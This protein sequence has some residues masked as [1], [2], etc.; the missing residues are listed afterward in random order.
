MYMYDGKAN[1]PKDVIHVTVS[2]SVLEIPCAAFKDCEKLETIKLPSSLFCIGY[3]AF[4][5]CHKLTK[6]VIPSSVISI[7][8]DAFFGCFGLED[9]NLPEGL[10]SIGDNAFQ[11]CVSL[12]KITLP[13]SLERLGG[14]T[15]GAF[16]QCCSL[17]EIM[18]PPLITVIPRG[19]FSCCSRLENVTLAPSVEELGKDSFS[20][21]GLLK[22]IDLPAT[23]EKI[24]PTAFREC[25]SLKIDN[26]TLPSAFTN[27]GGNDPFDILRSEPY[28]VSNLSNMKDSNVQL[29]P[30]PGS[31]DYFKGKLQRGWGPE[32]CGISLEQLFA[33]KKHP[34]YHRLG[35]D[36]QPD[37]SMVE[38][39]QDVIKPMTEGS[40]MC[41]ALLHNQKR[42]L[43]AKTHVS[44]SF[45]SNHRFSLYAFSV[46]QHSDY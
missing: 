10:S 35:R 46:F 14:R 32:Y 17:Q 37:Y 40:G 22:Y 34:L 41:Y 26:V 29:K 42:P 5:R 4:Y 3:S 44:V 1:V 36:G 11:Q 45:G 25:M 24:H 2:S 9:I 15:G 27:N 19:T 33:I 13:Q 43:K 16:Y 38:F 20:S 12:P 7:G 6:V 8:D 21:C 23:V 18:V 39:V 30:G 31:N 28:H